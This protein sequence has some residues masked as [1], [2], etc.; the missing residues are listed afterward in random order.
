[1]R[2]PFYAQWYGTFAPT[3]CEALYTTLLRGTSLQVQK[4]D[5]I[6][7]AGRPVHYTATFESRKTQLLETAHL[8]RQSCTLPCHGERACRVYNRKHNW[9]H[10]DTSHEGADSMRRIAILA[11]GAFEW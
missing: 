3:V 6:I 11:E 10:L 7:L 1:M 9:T 5:L 8:S 4:T 2:S